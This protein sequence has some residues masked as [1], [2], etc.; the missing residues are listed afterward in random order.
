MGLSWRSAVMELRFNFFSTHLLDGTLA[1]FMNFFLL[2]LI[3]ALERKNFIFFALSGISLGAAVLVKQSGILWATIPWII[4]FLCK[5]YRY[6]KNLIGVWLTTAS[7]LLTLYP[8]MIYG[9]NL[10]HKVFL[11]KPFG[12]HSIPWLAFNVGLYSFL[13]IGAWIAWKWKSKPNRMLEDLSWL[14]RKA[15]LFFP[16]IGL[17]LLVASILGIS[18]FFANSVFF[19]SRYSG[20]PT[21]L[22]DTIEPVFRGLFWFVVLACGGT[23]LLL[24]GIANID[25]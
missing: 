11:L 17:T 10:S 3:I 4:F 9:Y 25:F 15:G 21:Y 8:W 19:P 14:R 13:L 18:V 16:V 20:L 6:P 24:F 1:L 5:E 23:L 2:L 7:F 22:H 12:D